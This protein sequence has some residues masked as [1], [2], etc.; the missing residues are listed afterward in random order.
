MSVVA[1]ELVNLTD[2]ELLEKL[3]NTKAESPMA[4][5]I[6][7]EYSRRALLAQSSAAKAAKCTA[8]WTGVSAGAIAVSTIL[9]ALQIYL[10]RP[11]GTVRVYPAN[12]LVDKET[13]H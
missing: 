4:Y 7:A 8:V 12:W 2:D 3:S 1:G 13:R 10:E 11:N 5:A 6:H 9:L